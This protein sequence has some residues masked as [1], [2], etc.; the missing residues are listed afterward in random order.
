MVIKSFHNDY[1]GHTRVRVCS[2]HTLVLGI[3]TDRLLGCSY[4]I[5]SLMVTVL[6]TVCNYTLPVAEVTRDISSAMLTD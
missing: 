3:I 5:G 6:E 4:G 1:V 2:D